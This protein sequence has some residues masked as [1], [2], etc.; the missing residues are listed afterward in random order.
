M[1]NLLMMAALLGCLQLFSQTTKISGTVKDGISDEGLVGAYIFY[2]ENDFVAADLDG[3]FS[4]EVPNGSYTIK[5]SFVG[6]SDF[7]KKIEATGKPITITAKMQAN[8]LQE[9]E[10]VA[11]IARARETPVAFSTITPK[12][13]QEELVSQDIPMLLNSTPGVYATQTG[14]GDGDTRITI[15]GFNQ[16]N[17]SVML[18]GIPVNDME[19]GWV[20]WSNWFGLDAVTRSIQV[21]RG[22][23]ATK[24]ASP[25]VGGSLNIIT[26]GIESKK[27]GSIKQEVGSNGFLRT[28]LGLNTGRLKNGFGVTFAGSFKTGDGW[29]D[30]TWTEGYFYY[31]KIEKSLGKHLLSVSA[32]GAPQSHA[33]RSFTKSIA[34]YDATT[35]EKLGITDSVSFNEIKGYGTNF[36]SHWG[37][38][39]RYRGPNND[40]IFANREV[41]NERVNYYHKPLFT[42]KDFWSISDKLYLSTIAYLSIGNGGGT[43]LNT[44]SPKVD[45]LGQIDFQTYYDNNAFGP[46]S[47]DPSIDSTERKSGTYLRSSINNH[48][49]YG[50]LATLEYKMS[51]QF[52]LSG[53]LDARS[54]KGEHYREV[55]D[56]LGGDYAVEKSNANEKDG[57][58]REGDKIGYH[59]DALVKWGGSFLQLEFSNSLWSAFIN[60]SGIYNGYKRID[61]FR[62]KEIAIGDTVLTLGYNDTI[63]Y[64][65]TVYTHFSDGVDYSQTDWKWIPGYTVKTGVNYNINE[66]HNVFVNFG[67]LSRTPRFQNVI[68][69]NNK[70]FRDI[71]N[72]EVKAAELGYGIKKKKYAINLNGYYTLWENKP[73]DRGQSVQIDGENVSVN[74]NGLNALHMGAELDFAINITKKLEFEGLASFGDWRWN[75]TDSVKIYDDNQK[76]LATVFF[77]ATDVHV[78]DAAQMQFASSLRYQIIKG[79]FVKG[80]WTYFGKQ[81]AQFDPLTLYDEDAGRDSWQVPDY[82]LFEVFAGYRFKIEKTTFDLNFGILN[83][84]NSVYISDAQN[85]DGFATPYNDFDAKSAGVFYGMGRRYNTSLK[86]TF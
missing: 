45:P 80:K 41:L 73:A 19:N 36:N 42:L 79:L 25:A 13:I 63:D 12:K 15:R 30:Q 22:L 32:M 38:V 46:F 69:F 55:Y 74:I 14:G 68:D 18:D 40:T 75:S 84:L 23:G 47:I 56:L 27:G 1:K 7:V 62:P 72:E 59:N 28:T 81:Y 67:Y 43:S 60:I 85:N 50:A 83:L 20:Y 52:S 70:F 33:Q 86:I 11:D 54:Y 31:L 10:V 6:Y 5:I 34:Y 57:I 58:K 66:Y 49:W 21:Q 3:N 71:K 17:I 64:N 8:T 37:Y 53:G 48:F 39:K 44:S 4:F 35:A 76:L 78:G 65:G 29:V 82:Q 51:D 77:D 24:I 61:Y 16:R 26:Q 9:V 2:G